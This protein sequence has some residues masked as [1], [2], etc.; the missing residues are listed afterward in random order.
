MLRVTAVTAVGASRRAL[1]ASLPQQCSR[2]SAQRAYTTAE[3]SFSIHTP[4]ANK[5]THRREATYSRQPARRPDR[6][7]SGQRSWPSS[8]TS[9]VSTR[10][11]TKR[12]LALG[13]GQAQQTSTSSETTN[14]Q[15]IALQIAIDGQDINLISSVW[16]QLGHNVCEL[17][18]AEHRKLL[19]LC[20]SY[21]SSITDADQARSWQNR[22]RDFASAASLTGDVDLICDWFRI[23]FANGQA[24][25]VVNIWQDIVRTRLDS[26]PIPSSPIHDS[27][28]SI[29]I[30]A[31]ETTGESFVRL[32]VSIDGDRIDIHDMVCL[33][34][35]AC[36]SSSHASHSVELFEKVEFGSP[37]RLFFNM[38]RAKRIFESTPVSSFRTSNTY[39]PV[40][41]NTIQTTL[42]NIELARGLSSGSGGPQRIARLLGSLFQMRQNEQAY[43]IFQTAMRASSPPN[44]WLSLEALGQ[45]TSLSPPPG[46][47]AQWTESC[48]SVCLSNLIAAE[49]T[50]LAMDVWTQLQQKRVYPTPRIWNA[51]LDGYGRAK[52]H[53]AAEQTWSAA[54]A[55]ASKDASTQMKLP[56]ELMY[57]TMIDVYL[58]AKKVD[59]AMALL[60][61]MLAKSDRHGG[62]LHVQAE[63][64]NAVLHGLFL[65][66]RHAQAQ[67]VLD[68]MLAKGPTPNINTINTFLRAH[69]RVGDLEA[70][71]S[72][73]RLAGKLKLT[74]DV[75]TFTTILDALLR[76]GGESATAA[77]VRT[78]DI[79]KGMGVQPNI[80]TYT[81]MIKACLVG[82]ETA[83][84]EL[85]SQSL[86]DG[87]T[88]RKMRQLS[89]NEVRIEAA[90][91]LL[92]RLI[93]SKVAPSEITYTALIGGCLQ[94]PDAVTH[95]FATKAI[96]RQ[97]HTLPKPLHRLGESHQTIQTWSQRSPHV[98]LAL[99]LLDQMKT[100]N[101]PPT[102]ATFRFLIEGLCSPHTDQPAF[103]RAMDLLDDML[104]RTPISQPS[105]PLGPFASVTLKATPTFPPTMHAPNHTTW[106]TVFS[107]L[108]DRLENGPRDRVAVTMCGRALV[109]ATRLVREMGTL[110]GAEG[111]MSLSRLV[112]RA[113]AHTSKLPR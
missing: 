17:G 55:H 60:S 69:G 34:A 47:R 29:S 14:A 81:A 78:L 16:Q 113:A 37:F 23:L 98:S 1:L 49:R 91:E 103:I 6:T 66:G 46:S 92:E 77:V 63:T 110:S 74:P 40:D 41:W 68:H 18:Q 79:M 102:S 35:L 21:S 58:R 3:A 83:Q 93:K 70:L 7:H 13:H 8:S 12:V 65:N 76:K 20:S 107:C 104:L 10:T 64:Y 82:A 11:N 22:F 62:Q 56:D 54:I 39:K 44:A 112:E 27:S 33:V 75:V 5:R 106:I 26:M 61:D 85:V 109:T 42:W 111:G 101:L 90:L 87:S 48:W 28:E 15:L 31:A 19:R 105:R 100:R 4:K 80:V 52:N 9:Y 2:H 57:T 86:L 25:D 51:L 96:P 108:L 24:Q 45:T 50:D 38:S 95:A 59:E 32:D 88:D 43:T 30:S 67:S 84:L 97:F 73:L 71:A 53:T 94:N 99:L 36:S 72:T 89:S